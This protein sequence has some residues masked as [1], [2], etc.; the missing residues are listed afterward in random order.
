MNPFTSI[1]GLE[2]D[3]DVLTAS[4]ITDQ[5]QEFSFSL[6]KTTGVLENYTVDGTTLIEKGP[7]LN[8]YRATIDNDGSMGQDLKNIFD[9]MT[10]PQVEVSVPTAKE[11]KDKVILVSLKGDLGINAA[12]QVDY[13]FYSNG[14]IV[15]T[16]SLLPNANL[17]NL[18][19]V[20][21]KMEVNSDLQNMEY[22]GRGPVENY[23]DR[24]SGSLVDVY[25]YRRERRESDRRWPGIQVLS[26]RRSFRKPYR[27]QMDFFDGQNG[28]GLMIAAEDTMETGATR[29]QPEAMG[30]GNRGTSSTSAGRHIYQIEQSES[31]VWTVDYMQRG[32]GNNSCGGSTALPAFQVPSDRNVTHSFRIIPI[33][34]Q[35]DKMEES[36]L[37]F[38]T[39]F[40][41]IDKVTINGVEMA[42]FDPG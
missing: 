24:N 10:D 36:K 13:K 23:S 8:L 28:N 37:D 40:N 30:I 25:Q 26:I 22:Y 4:G 3:A 42:S 1:E 5:G 41:V 15:V 33:T 35:T 29:Y 2:D 38:D 17:G 34:N 11:T 27:C 32:L 7:V 31:I 20:G 9:T 21:M 12:N 18:P 16:N 39:V 6:N 14:D 19:R